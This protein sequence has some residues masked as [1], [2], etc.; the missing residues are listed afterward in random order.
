MSLHGLIPFCCHGSK[1]VIFEHLLHIRALFDIFI[2]ANL[3]VNLLKCEFTK[4][5]VT[6][7][8]K[9]AGQGKVCL[10]IYCCFCRHFST[11]AMP[12]TIVLPGGVDFCW[13]PVCQ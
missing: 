12:L 13:T 8:G 9:V 7:F 6:Y 1:I 4:S 11:V 3:T 2:K 10:I 5:M